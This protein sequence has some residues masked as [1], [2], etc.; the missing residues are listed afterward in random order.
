MELGQVSDH[1]PTDRLGED[2]RKIV[3]DWLSV[4]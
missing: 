3:S 2:I 4:I 1:G